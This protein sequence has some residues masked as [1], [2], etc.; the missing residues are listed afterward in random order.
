MP[1]DSCTI[2]LTGPLEVA[3]GRRSVVVACPAAGTI[4]SLL[5]SLV[6]E[7]PGAAR[8]LGEAARLAEATGPLPTAMLVVRDGAALPASLEVAVRPGDRLTLLP[9]IS[10]G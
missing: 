8:F 2:E 7:H 1:A 5:A 4:G 10:G 6:A 9:M 3:L